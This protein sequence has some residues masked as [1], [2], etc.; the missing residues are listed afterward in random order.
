M[1]FSRFT[2]LPLKS[3]AFSGQPFSLLDGPVHQDLATILEIDI[4]ENAARG[5]REHWQARQL[6]NLLNH[7]VARSTFWRSRLPVAPCTPETLSAL[8]VLS[9]RELLEQ[10]QSEGSLMTPP[11]S[12]DQIETYASSGS[13]GVPVKVHL[14]SANAR[15]NTMHGIAQHFIEAEPLDEPRT[16]IKPASAELMMSATEKLRVER[17]PTWIGRMSRVFRDAPHKIIEFAKDGSALVEELRKDKVG[18]LACP[19]TFMYMI[20]ETCG[21][22]GL[23]EMGISLWLH[24]T[25][26]LDDD[27]AARI[28][29]AG[30]PIRSGYSCSEAGVIAMECTKAP[31]FYHVAY[32][33]VIVEC[34]EETTVQVGGD[35]LGRVLITHL[36]SYATPLIRYDVGDFARLH[37]RCACGHDGQALS[38]LHGRGKFF[39]RHPDG[40]LLHFPVYSARLLEVAPFTEF[41]IHQPDPSRIIVRLGGRVH[42]T[43]E[44][45]ARVRAYVIRASDSVFTVEVVT[46]R[47][48]DWTKNPK[49]LA[50]TS[51]VA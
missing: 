31:G 1:T 6:A 18:H 17:H 26:N 34:D 47:E 37:S 25:D 24:H 14:T 46:S 7:A 19:S 27:L 33:N 45:E 22:E 16:F 15:L 43:T 42:L 13:T 49:R 9:R 39:L 23:R 44:E 38:R 2:S 20:L 50:F 30:I 12:G 4:L 51:A 11:G 21:V 8:P 5:V 40:R 41:W 28:R 35:D 3:A 10:V 29:G 32:S 48:I 36:H